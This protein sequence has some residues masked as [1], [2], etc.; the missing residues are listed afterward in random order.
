MDIEILVASVNQS[1]MSNAQKNT[2]VATLNHPVI[3]HPPIFS[4]RQ[5][6]AKEL[7][8]FEQDCEAY[9]LNAKGGDPK[10][11]QVA[12]IITAFKD[13]LVWDWITSNRVTLVKLTFNEFMKRLHDMFLPKDLEEN[14]YTQIL[15]N[16]MPRNNKR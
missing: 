16:M 5:I 2:R 1:K 10:E 3:N 4:E 11:Q 9:F 7:M 12:C 15:G 8:I 6:T 13:P 14:I